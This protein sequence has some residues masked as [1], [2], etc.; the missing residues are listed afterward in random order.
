MYTY[1]F[2]YQRID[3][4]AI[5]KFI[6][7]VKIKRSCAFQIEKITLICDNTIENSPKRNIELL[8]YK[9]QYSRFYIRVF[10]FNLAATS[11]AIDTIT[12]QH[13]TIFERL[14]MLRCSR[15]VVCFFYCIDCYWRNCQMKAKQNVCLCIQYRDEVID[16]TIN[17]FSNIIF[18]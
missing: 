18:V 14:C 4:V 10:H 17:D 12:K 16:V 1:F 15:G 9:S 2:K 8:S 6:Q 3:G 11:I 13:D 7:K 5:R